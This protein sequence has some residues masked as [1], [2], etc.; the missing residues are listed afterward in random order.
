MADYYDTWNFGAEEDPEYR[1]KALEQ[2]LLGPL[3]LTLTGPE[4]LRSPDAPASPAELERKRQR[5]AETLRR[6]DEMFGLDGGLVESLR[7]VA[8]P[9]Y[10][11]GDSEGRDD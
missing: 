1:R 8:R 4:K 9:H 10:G 3:G 5:E 7:R 2:K 11:V 6:H